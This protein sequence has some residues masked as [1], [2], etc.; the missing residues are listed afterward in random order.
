MS[1]TP[2]DIVVKLAILD[3]C[4]GLGYASDFTDIPPDSFGMVLG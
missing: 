2:L 4:R 3:V 1:T